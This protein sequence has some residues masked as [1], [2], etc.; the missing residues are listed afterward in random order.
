MK[1]KAMAPT[2]GRDGR[3]VWRQTWW[4]H[5][6]EAVAVAFGRAVQ[7]LA[8][9]ANGS[10]LAAALLIVLCKLPGPALFLAVPKD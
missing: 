3:L 7:Y 10:C 9:G 2:P 6:A 8:S 4:G 5:A 1:A